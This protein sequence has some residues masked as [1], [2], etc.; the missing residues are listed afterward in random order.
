MSKPASKPALLV[1][2]AAGGLAQL[3]AESV[4]NDY[5]CFGIDARPMRDGESFAGEFTR[6]DYAHRKLTE[7]FR[8]RKF[9]ALVHLGRI[10]ETQVMNVQA[11]YNLNVLG[12]RNLLDHARK[13]DVP[14]V[15]AVSTFHVYGAHRAN[16]LY[17]DEDEP[18]RASQ[19]FPELADAVELDNYV[20][21]FSIQYPDIRT[22]LLRPANI[23]G[24][25][26][27]NETSMLLR[28]K[29][30]PT[31]L[32]Y[33][34]LTQFVH[35]LDFARA[36]G[37][38]LPSPERGV[39]NVAGEGVIYWRQAVE[40]AGATPLPVPFPVAH[41]ILGGALS[42]FGLKFPRHLADYFRYPTVVTDETFRAKFG[43]L[44][45]LTTVEALQ[46]LQTLRARLGIKTA[47]P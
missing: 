37:L 46:S 45:S 30:C 35:E 26:I 6:V 39:Y 14:N 32:G 20:K 27:R 5:D 9:H 22:V 18:L 25:R 21:T 16:H 3:F 17:I 4:A 47:E 11:R 34:P 28:Q 10:R 33:D 23:V 38:V 36:L 8:A 29:Y 42:R 19:T 43:Y 24:E 40:C 2:G 13:H 15:I 44:P 12:T 7:I 31:I 1:T 41:W